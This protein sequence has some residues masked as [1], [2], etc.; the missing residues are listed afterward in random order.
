MHKKGFLLI[1]VAVALLTGCQDID[2]PGNYYTFTGQTVASFLESD[3]NNS[4]S[5]FIY[6]LKG[7]NLWTT[8]STYGTYTCL[9]PT[10]SAFE[11]YMS[12]HNIGSLSELTYNQL[13]T[14]ARSHI[15]EQTF[16]C[17]DLIEGS[18]PYPNMLDRLL[19]YS[20]DSS[21]NGSQVRLK[22]KINKTSLLL[23]MDD[24]VQN[25]VVHIVDKVLEPS[26][27]TVAD[28][29]IADTAT[30]LFAQ[31]LEITHFKD[32][33]TAFMDRTY[34][35]PGGDSCNTLRPI[36]YGDIKLIWPENRLFK[37]TGFVERDQVF[38]NAG[39]NTFQDLVNYA[40]SIYD[41]DNGQ[42]LADAT[43][44]QDTMFRNPNNP[45]FK[46]VAYHFLPE[47][48]GYNDLNVT[49]TDIVT[50]YIKRDKYD[51]EDFYETMLPHSIMRISTPNKPVGVYINRKGRA[52]VE[53]EGVRVVA[54]S[55]TDA[56]QSAM[57]GVY[58]YIDNILVYSD[59]V[60]KNALNV[61]I[62]LDCTT[63]SPDFINSGG[64]NRP[65]DHEQNNTCTALKKGYVKNFDFSNETL[66]LVQFRDSYYSCWEGDQILVFGIYDV[67]FKLP[68]VPNSGTYEI[69]FGYFAE[70][71]RGV[72]Q[73]YFGDAPC[74]IPLDMRVEGLDPKIGWIADSE[75]KSDREIVAHEK[76]MRARGYMKSLDSFKA[77]YSSTDLRGDYRNLRRI[78]TTEYLDAN[79][80]YTLRLR[81]VIDNPQAVMQFDYIELVPKNVYYGLTPEDFH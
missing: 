28:L 36:K 37:F 55:E 40:D 35:E 71:T 33:L 15:M 69:R 14:I 64:R 74:G 43:N 79:T 63:L 24:T 72:V 4:F 3:P 38:R 42:Y 2:S 44:L 29:I 67:T 17:T 62:R 21:M 52:P 27:Q 81:Q 58:H 13:D 56:N 48:M 20:V 73:W 59:D 51:I 41:T 31:A 23:E 9:A 50:N 1:N 25:G 7:C 10:N 75:F 53:V 6:V 34:I 47:Q 70:E 78:V 16:Y 11:K 54:P 68:P 46:F 32:S 39:I 60:R 77:P 49:N 12:D 5:Q 30:T 66:L 57:N 8:L 61:R 65:G 80:D 18:I 26:T 19:T 45:L 76:T 22:H